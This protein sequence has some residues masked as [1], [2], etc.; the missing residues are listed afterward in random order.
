[1]KE[2]LINNKKYRLRL[3]EKIHNNEEAYFVGYLCGDGSFNK[4]TYKR[5]ARLGIS[6]INETTIEWMRKKFSPDSSIHSIVPVNKKRNIVTKKLSYRITFSSKF[7]KTFNKFGILGIKRD[8]RL[9]N[10]S[11]RMMNAY[12]LGLFDADGHI[13]WGRRKD[14]NRLWANFGITHQSYDVLSKIQKFIEEELNISSSIRTRKDEDCMDLKFSNRDSI[15]KMYNFL[16]KN[17]IFHDKKKENNF[18]TFIS[19]YTKH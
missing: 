19:E 1:M 5:K 8:R 4:G 15:V 17:E 12:V 10:I 16:Y 13:S 9:V 7:Q 14:R 2:Y 3:F 18:K 11:R 6:S